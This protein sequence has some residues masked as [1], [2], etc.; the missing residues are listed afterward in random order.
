MSQYIAGEPALQSYDPI[1][2][3]RNYIDALSVLFLSASQNLRLSKQATV[4]FSHLQNSE[5]SY[6]Q[7]FNHNSFRC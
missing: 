3:R 7:I 6:S 1:T 5:V 4:L 2:G